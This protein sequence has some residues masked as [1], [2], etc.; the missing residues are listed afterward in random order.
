M[1]LRLN[2]EGYYIIDSTDKL[3]EWHRMTD[4][5]HTERLSLMSERQ[6][7]KM[8]TKTKEIKKTSIKKE[9]KPELTDFQKW[10]K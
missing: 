8:A 10:F 2:K 1:S 3:K 7:P 4:M 9:N 6:K 5:S